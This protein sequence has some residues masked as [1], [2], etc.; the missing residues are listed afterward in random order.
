MLF[1]LTIP[2]ISELSF[3]LFEGQNQISNPRVL[4]MQSNPSRQCCWYGSDVFFNRSESRRTISVYLVP[5]RDSQL[6]QCIDTGKRLSSLCKSRGRHNQF[7]LTT[8]SQG[9]WPPA[10][11]LSDYKPFGLPG[12][13]KPKYLFN[14][15]LTEN[16]LNN[17]WINTTPSSTLNLT[18]SVIY[19][20]QF[21]LKPASVSLLREIFQKQS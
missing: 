19:L 9:S 2:F 1:R 21:S 7:A 20:I 16:I 10:S 4:Q 17:A 5:D 13:P 15:Y 11:C 8:M 14:V 3:P 18:P 12:H 6:R